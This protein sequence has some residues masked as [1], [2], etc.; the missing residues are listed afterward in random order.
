MTE[1][2]FSFFDPRFTACTTQKRFNFT[3]A[4]HLVVS[5]FY[6]VNI[7]IYALLRISFMHS[8][9]NRILHFNHKVFQCLNCI[10][11]LIKWMKYFFHLNQMNTYKTAMIITTITI[12]LFTKSAQFVKSI[13]LHIFL[14]IYSYVI[15]VACASNEWEEY[16]MIFELLYSLIP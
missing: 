7:H 6:E 14:F 9:Q 13:T 11:K 5:I 15:C 12:S 10:Q 1:F 3:I 2:N 4:I 8:N 16:R